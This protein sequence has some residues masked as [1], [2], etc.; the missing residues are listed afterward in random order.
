MMGTE[1]SVAKLHLKKRGSKETV[2]I[3][4]KRMVP[5]R[6]WRLFQQASKNVPEL[7]AALDEVRRSASSPEKQTRGLNTCMDKLQEHLVGFEH[8]LHQQY[9]LLER[10]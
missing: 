8:C 3:F 7:R 9:C 4:V 1:G 10:F 6:L 5:S 2:T